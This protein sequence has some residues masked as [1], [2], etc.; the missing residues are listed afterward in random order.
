[1]SNLMHL[2]N[3]T[4]L[5]L[6][7]GGLGLLL[8]VL[9]SPDA[10]A[11]PGRPWTE[12]RQ[13]ADDYGWTDLPETVKGGFIYGLGGT[14]DWRPF[15]GQTYFEGRQL[16]VTVDDRLQVVRERIDFGV[17]D[18]YIG[19]NLRKADALWRQYLRELLPKDVVS[20]ILDQPAA[21][22]ATVHTR[23]IGGVTRHRIL[24]GEGDD[25]A[26]YLEANNRVKAPGEPPPRL[27]SGPQYQLFLE[28]KDRLPKFMGDLAG[29]S[30][31]IPGPTQV[32]SAA[33]DLPL[34][35]AELRRKRVAAW[36]SRTAATADQPGEAY[37]GIGIRLRR[38]PMS[39]WVSEVLDGGPAALAGLR[40]DDRIVAID[41]A[42]ASLLSEDEA[43]RAIRGHAGSHVALRIERA[44]DQFSTLHI[45]RGPLTDP[46]QSPKINF[47]PGKCQARRT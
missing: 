4:T 24:I 29:Y 47:A 6:R 17:H 7:V 16:W 42:D 5:A 18:R 19:G 23:G 8:L 31:V 38:S 9:A 34:V 13:M 43:V 3:A 2:R 33:E 41:D 30:W 1:M 22:A 11:L 37:F 15:Q 21:K 10:T 39:L 27:E 25:F 12:V 40:A 44:Y 35:P 36:R 32:G 45:G 26:Y 20:R 28:S 14:H 46:L